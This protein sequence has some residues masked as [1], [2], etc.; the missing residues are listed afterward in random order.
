[1]RAVC[2]KYGLD[3]EWARKRLPRQMGSLMNA[4]IFGSLSEGEGEEQAARTKIGRR[5]RDF[6]LIG[7][8]RRI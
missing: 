4:F 6:I 3:L 7:L 1:M 2:R 5:M 8:T